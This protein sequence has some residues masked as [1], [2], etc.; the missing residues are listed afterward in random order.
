MRRSGAWSMPGPRQPRLS[1]V[2]LE[3]RIW[4]PHGSWYCRPGPREPAE[5]C[6]VHRRRASHRDIFQG[7]SSNVRS[8]PRLAGSVPAIGPLL[9]NIRRAPVGLTI[10]KDLWTERGPVSVVA[11]QGACVVV[12]PNSPYERGKYAERWVR[13][14]AEQDGVWIVY[15]NLVGGQ[16]GIVFYGDSVAYAPDGVPS[17]VLPSSPRTCSSSIWR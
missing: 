3:Q 16:D 4:G 2:C 13:H 7:T 6:R 10:C 14:H 1:W 11:Q 17:H 5:R 9:C 8:S 15:V 12:I